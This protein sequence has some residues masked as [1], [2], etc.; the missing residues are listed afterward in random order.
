MSYFVPSP[1]YESD[2][3]T[4]MLARTC[5][6]N[7]NPIVRSEAGYMY[8]SD[9][10]NIYIGPDTNSIY[11]KP[12]SYHMCWPEA[13]LRA[14]LGGP[15]GALWGRVIPST[16]L[17]RRPTMRARHSAATPRSG[18]QCAMVALGVARPDQGDTA[19]RRPRTT[20]SRFE[21]SSR[22]VKVNP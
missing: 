18:S 2:M 17:S 14:F 13:P 16:P 5:K 12:P 8:E 20:P 15:V 22:R 6:T 21:L 19:I 3:Q 4:N 10:V 11:I 9:I 1:K 7:M